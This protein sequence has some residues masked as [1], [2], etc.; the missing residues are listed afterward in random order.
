MEREVEPK[1][2]LNR[3]TVELLGQTADEAR[4]HAPVGF[5]EHVARRAVM[6]RYHELRQVHNDMTRLG[7][8]PVDDLEP[9]STN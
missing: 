4:R 3:A 8:L 9:I 7:F 2:I 1:G 5:E 6:L